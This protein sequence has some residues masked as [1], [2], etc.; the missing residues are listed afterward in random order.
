MRSGSIISSIPV[1]SVMKAC[2]R[3]RLPNFMLNELFQNPMLVCDFIRRVK[4]GYC[5]F[6]G[7]IHIHVIDFAAVGGIA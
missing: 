6:P 5:S 3:R 1:V 2:I 7:G 4:P